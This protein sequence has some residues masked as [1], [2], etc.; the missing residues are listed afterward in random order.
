MVRLGTVSKIAPRTTYDDSE[1]HSL[2][3]AQNNPTM[4]SFSSH[5]NGAIRCD[6]GAPPRLCW[7]PVGV[8]I[9]PAECMDPHLY[10][11]QSD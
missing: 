2:R 9:M 10:V 4:T 1:S 3:T 5:R 11:Y 8:Q 6:A 7:H